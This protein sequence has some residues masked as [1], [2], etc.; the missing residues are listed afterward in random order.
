MPVTALPLQVLRLLRVQSQVLIKSNPSF[1][2]QSGFPLC[3][4]IGSL[5]HFKLALQV[6]KLLD[7]SPDA[8]A[9]LF[10]LQLFLLEKLCLLV[11]PVFDTMECDFPSH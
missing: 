5:D 10:D 1:F 9:A 3:F 11:D 7:L 2:D 8:I 6:I 4:C